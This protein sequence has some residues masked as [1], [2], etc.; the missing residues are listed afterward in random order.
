MK[1]NASKTLLSLCVSLAMTLAVCAQEKPK[2]YHP[3]ANAQADVQNAVKKAQVHSATMAK[4]LGNP[5]T[6]ARVKRTKR[7]EV[8]PSPNT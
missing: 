8:C 4:P 1:I 5:P 7:C 6:S 3:E 2:L